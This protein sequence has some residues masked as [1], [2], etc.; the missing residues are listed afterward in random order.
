MCGSFDDIGV[1][2]FEKG[3]C[4]YFVVSFDVIHN[5][6]LWSMII[7]SKTIILANEL[8]LH[9]K[10]G[11]IIPNIIKNVIS[12]IIFID[13]D[14]I[15]TIEVQY[16]SFAHRLRAFYYT[17]SLLSF[18]IRDIHQFRC[19]SHVLLLVQHIPIGN[20]LSIIPP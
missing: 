9:P 4:E 8:I 12:L 13:I 16:K 3:E 7:Y 15:S 11:I 5:L 14:E 1:I 17:Y 6:A 19:T 18:G 2:I 10:D 20:I